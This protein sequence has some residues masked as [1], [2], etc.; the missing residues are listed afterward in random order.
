MKLTTADVLAAERQEHRPL[1]RPPK[2][3]PDEWG[4]KPNEGM[5]VPVAEDETSGTCFELEK[6]DYVAGRP[7]VVAEVY[8]NE[9]AAPPL[10]IPKDKDGKPLWDE[11]KPFEDRQLKQGARAPPQEASPASARA[12]PRAVPRVGTP[13]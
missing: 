8:G 9:P 12:A 5:E 11:S 7:D 3:R 10:P 2:D 1:R 6:L 13:A 4:V